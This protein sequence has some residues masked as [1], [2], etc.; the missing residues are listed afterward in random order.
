MQRIDDI[1]EYLRNFS[2]YGTIMDLGDLLEIL[3]IALLVYYVLVWMK[4]T[5]AW[6]LLKGLIVI[7]AFC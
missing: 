2:I 6:T 5:R 7:F 3:I 4:A 1:V